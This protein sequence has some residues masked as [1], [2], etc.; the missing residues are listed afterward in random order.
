VRLAPLLRAYAEKHG[1]DIRFNT[2]LESFDRRD[3][4]VTGFL[5]QFKSGERE[6]VSAAYLVA[7]D[8]YGGQ[9]REKLGIGRSGPGVLQHWMNLIF[10]TDLSPFL[11]GRRFTSCF[12]TDI[13]ASIVPRDPRWLLALQY[14]PENGESPEDFDEQRTRDLVRQ[15]AGRHDTR[16]DLFDARSWEVAAFIADRFREGR[17]FIL[18]DAAHTMPPT[19]GFGGNTGIHDAQNLAWKL[20]YVL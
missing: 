11:K 2:E 20:A 18:G 4:S 16:A 17:A 14:Q 1:A 9:T 7:A 12:V 13:N 19:G 6:V 10:E 3:D 8:G 5:R 15:A